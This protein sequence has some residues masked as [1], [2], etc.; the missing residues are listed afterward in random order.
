MPV[1]VKIPPVL[2]QATL[3]FM[4]KRDVKLSYFQVGLQ[5]NVADCTRIF[6]KETFK[7]SKTLKAQNAGY[8]STDWV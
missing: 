2:V 1:N 3:N 6:D 7:T 8:F 4:F 5:K